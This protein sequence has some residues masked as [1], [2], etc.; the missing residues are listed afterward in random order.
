M[1]REERDR[2]G[3][4]MLGAAWL[5]SRFAEAVEAGDYPTPEALR[6]SLRDGARKVLVAPEGEARTRGE[7]Y[8]RLAF[9]MVDGHGRRGR[10]RTLAGHLFAVGVDPLLVLAL[11]QAQNLTRCSPPL[12]PAEV[13]ELVR[14]VARREAGKLE[15]VA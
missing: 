3:V 6:E 8:G 5:A 11:L 10:L 12:H 15:A 2:S 1:T 7:H 4:E 13:E 14:W 9:P